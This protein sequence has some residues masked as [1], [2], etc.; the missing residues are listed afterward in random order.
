VL[1]PKFG[2]TGESANGIAVGQIYVFWVALPKVHVNI[3]LG[4]DR[5]PGAYHVKQRKSRMNI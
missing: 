2:K 1:T 3:Y 5:F 4:E